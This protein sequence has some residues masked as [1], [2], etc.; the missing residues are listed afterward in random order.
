MYSVAEQV[1]FLHMEELLT[2]RNVLGLLRTA[3]V[4]I[5]DLLFERR[6]KVLASGGFSSL[7][8]LFTGLVFETL[9]QYVG[10]VKADEIQIINSFSRKFLVNC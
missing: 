7:Y 8:C 4:I 1:L 3:Q 2:M 9:E 6:S 10:E 5:S